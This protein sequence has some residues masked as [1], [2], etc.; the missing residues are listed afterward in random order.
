MKRLPTLSSCINRGIEFTR[1]RAYR[2]YDR[3]WTEQK[4]A[5]IEQKN[6]SMVRRFVGHDRCSGQAAGQTMAHL[7]ARQT[8]TAQFPG[9]LAFGAG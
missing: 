6:G 3:A 2:S 4:H 5:W 7:Y 9:L 1:P 8:Y